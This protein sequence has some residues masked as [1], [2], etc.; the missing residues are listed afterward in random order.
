MTFDPTHPV[1]TEVGFMSHALAPARI[2]LIR[3]GS[4]PH[5]GAADGE[6]RRLDVTHLVVE[7]GVAQD[8]AITLAATTEDDDIDPY[9][10]EF[11]LVPLEARRLAAQILSAVENA[12]GDRT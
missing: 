5:V 11:D 2:P 10:F 12:I 7:F 8:G 1:S 6:I 4:Y 9:G 3:A